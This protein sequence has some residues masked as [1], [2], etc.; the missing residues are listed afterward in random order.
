M[1]SREG[2][3][4]WREA[5]SRVCQY[6]S[7]FLSSGAKPGSLVALYMQNAPEFIFAWIGLWAIGC[8]PVM[9][10]WNLGAESLLHCIKISGAKIMLVDGEAGCQER[11]Q[12]E[13]DRIEGELQV[14]IVILT[15]SLKAEIANLVAS[16]PD[17]SYRDCVVGTSPGALFYT[18]S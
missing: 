7:Y 14:K 15:N 17:D 16:R 6:A 9:L 10:N 2:I 13:R 11:I 4:T 5:H 3:Y 12:K 8:A 18:R 1:W